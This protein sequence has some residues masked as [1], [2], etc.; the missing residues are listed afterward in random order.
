MP[1]RVYCRL[2][3]KTTKAHD[4]QLEHHGGAPDDGDIHLDRSQLTTPN[5]GFCRPAGALLVMGG[6]HHGH[7]DTQH[8]AH[9]QGHERWPPE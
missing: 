8:H 2:L 9:E 7:H 4:Q 1:T 6:A 3:V 5:A